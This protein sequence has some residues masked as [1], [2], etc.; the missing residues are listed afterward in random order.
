MGLG[1][2][3]LDSLLIVWPSQIFMFLEKVWILELTHNKLLLNDAI[4]LRSTRLWV[5]L[6]K[7]SPVND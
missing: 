7:C 6:K 2:S 5:M 1:Q 3:K 4:P